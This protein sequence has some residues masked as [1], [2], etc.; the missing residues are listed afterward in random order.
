MKNKFFA[1]AL[2][3]SCFNMIFLTSCL[4]NANPR[5][6]KSKYHHHKQV[7]I[8]ATQEAPKVDLIVHKDTMKGWN[9]EIK[10][11]NFKFAPERINTNSAL[12]EGHAHLFINGKKVTRLY[13]SWY[14]LNN[15]EPGNNEITVTLNTNKHEDLTVNGKLIK[16]T[17]SVEVTAAKQQADKQQHNNKHQM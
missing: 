11:D 4:A 16:D 15:L 17:E 10:V 2:G 12:N 7:E 6:H 5:T 9:L 13:A 14:Y 8:P 1:A 3:L